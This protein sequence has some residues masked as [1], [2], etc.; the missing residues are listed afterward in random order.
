MT[1]DALYAFGICDYAAHTGEMRQRTRRRHIVINRYT[2]R[3]ADRAEL[4]HE[5]KTSIPVLIRL[6]T[7]SSIL[8]ICQ[9]LYL[10]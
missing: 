9:E 4:Q 2:D 10:D 6:R 3:A 7:G 8:T 5:S 1:R